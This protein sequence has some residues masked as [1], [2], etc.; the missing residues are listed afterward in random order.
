[1]K[2]RGRIEASY[3]GITVEG[4]NHPPAFPRTEIATFLRGM[5][6]TV[7]ALALFGDS[8][9]SFLNVPL[10][11]FYISLFREN[12]IPVILGSLFVGNALISNLTSTGAFEIVCNNQVLWSKLQSGKA[13]N[14][15]QA[16]THLISRI[17]E[18][19]LATG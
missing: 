5:Q 6:F 4:S 15:P 9:F 19:C 17:R 7:L 18:V 10:P 1:M 3:P 2:I 11:Q 14:T 12:K 13:P 16:L 8:I